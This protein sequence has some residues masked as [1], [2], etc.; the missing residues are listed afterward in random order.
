M[1]R[2]MTES[3]TETTEETGEGEGVWRSSL[4]LWWLLLGVVLLLL[5]LVLL[6]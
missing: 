3:D 4:L 2:N 1:D 6:L 5:A